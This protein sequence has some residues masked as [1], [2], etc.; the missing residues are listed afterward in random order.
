MHQSSSNVSIIYFLS[1]QPGPPLSSS[2][3]TSTSTSTSS[4]SFHISF[5]LKDDDSRRIK[6]LPVGGTYKL[7]FPRDLPES[8]QTSTFKHGIRL[9]S[10]F[11][12]SPPFTTSHSKTLAL[13]TSFSHWTRE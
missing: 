1:P 5:K 12:A 11:A 2:S 3:S 8:L 4:S 9:S 6:N 10:G 13:P 7:S